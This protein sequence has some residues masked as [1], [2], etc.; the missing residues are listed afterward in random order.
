MM[1]KKES[2]TEQLNNIVQCSV[3]GEEWFNISETLAL[4]AINDFY[5]TRNLDDILKKFNDGDIIPVK[6]VLYKRIRK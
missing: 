4:C 3:N 5:S 6:Y 2:K 1:S